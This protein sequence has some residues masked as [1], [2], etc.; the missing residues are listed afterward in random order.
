MIE[1][2]L[3]VMP[4]SAQG[5]R[6]FSR[7]I[8]P[9]VSRETTGWI[10]RRLLWRRDAIQAFEQE[11]RQTNAMRRGWGF[12]RYPQPALLREMIQFSLVHLGQLPSLRAEWLLERAE[13]KRPD[14]EMIACWMEKDE[15]A[16]AEW[17]RKE[18][19]HYRLAYGCSPLGMEALTE[20]AMLLARD[21]MRQYR[22]E[23]GLAHL[24]ELR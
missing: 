4:G 22:T 1:S 17:V 20:V 5:E 15:W 24:N 12:W 21:R 8:A 2:A 10:C 6:P 23:H 18:A 9:Q 11:S 13:S 3:W 19:R 14:A 16:L 7:F